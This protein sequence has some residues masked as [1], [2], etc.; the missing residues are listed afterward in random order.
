MPIDLVELS[1]PNADDRI[2]D[3][4]QEEKPDGRLRNFLEGENNEQQ[5]G[6]E[7]EMKE[8]GAD[9]NDAQT[10]GDNR[11]T[12]EGESQNTFEGIEM[13]GESSGKLKMEKGDSLE[14]KLKDFFQQNAEKLMKNETKGTSVEKWATNKAKEL[15]GDSQREENDLAEGDKYIEL[16]LSDPEN[17]QIKDRGDNEDESIVENNNVEKDDRETYEQPVKNDVETTKETSQ[18][19]DR[20]KQEQPTIESSHAQ[21]EQAYNEQMLQF[22]MK[23]STFLNA[24]TKFGDLNQ[25]QEGS[26]FNNALKQLGG[27][28]PQDDTNV[29]DYLVSSIEEGKMSWDDVDTLLNKKEK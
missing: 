24:D 11:K 28:M 27:E 29:S 25:S 10:I 18:E 8:I 20:E 9:N 6:V 3:E 13:E 22:K 12:Q 14:Q 19:S 17:I 23:D 4:E 1:E 15:L 2:E 21:D 26:D 5:E 7:Q 16:D